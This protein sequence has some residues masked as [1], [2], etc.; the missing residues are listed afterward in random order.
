MLAGPAIGAANTPGACGFAAGHTP[1]AV[2]KK[3]RIG[4]YADSRLRGAYLPVADSRAKKK[5]EF[6]I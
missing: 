5:S 6:E 1:H 3:R 2:I 4:F